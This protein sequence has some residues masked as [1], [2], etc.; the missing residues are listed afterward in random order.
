MKCRLPNCELEE[1]CRQHSNQL[2]TPRYCKQICARYVG[3][4]YTADKHLEIAGT[5]KC[6]SHQ[7]S[8]RSDNSAH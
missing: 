8:P 5:I 3:L 6:T 1:N 4:A 7:T 2:M